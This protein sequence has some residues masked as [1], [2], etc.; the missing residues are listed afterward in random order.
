MSSALSLK[1]AN[2]ATNYTALMLLTKPV[3]TLMFI[4]KSMSFKKICTRS[5]YIFSTHKLIHWFGYVLLNNPFDLRH[6]SNSV[7]SSTIPQY[8]YSKK[9]QVQMSKEKPIQQT[10]TFSQ[11]YFVIS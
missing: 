10:V 7:T 1:V 11:L 3:K 4:I 2:A 5:P 9:G 6:F 8:S